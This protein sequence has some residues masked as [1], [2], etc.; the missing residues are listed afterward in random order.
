[1]R[2]QQLRY[3]AIVPKRENVVKEIEFVKGPDGSAPIIMGVTV[4]TR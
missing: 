3:L 2:G 4:E 1:L